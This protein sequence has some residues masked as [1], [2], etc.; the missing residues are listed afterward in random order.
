MIEVI[1]RLHYTTVYNQFVLHQYFTK[2][3]LQR[4][5]DMAIRFVERRLK[6]DCV[7][8][9]MTPK[10]LRRTKTPDPCSYF[11]ACPCPCY[12]AII[13]KHRKEAIETDM[14]QGIRVKGGLVSVSGRV[15]YMNV[16]QWNLHLM[17][18]AHLSG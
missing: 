17:E 12:S 15:V 18:C 7:Q 8:I 13:I 16:S 5:L 6:Y 9:K 10:R 3:K 1:F 2:N 11:Q 14:C 4:K